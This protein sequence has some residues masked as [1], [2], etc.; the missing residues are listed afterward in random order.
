M[1]GRAYNERR[2]PPPMLGGNE[3]PIC[4][5]RTR[6]R[7]VRVFRVFGRAPSAVFSRWSD[8]NLVNASKPVGN[9]PATE[10]AR[11]SVNL[12]KRSC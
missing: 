11:V 8:V 6:V 12:N 1:A 9:E 10:D 5:L 7:D 2:A 3:D 4:A